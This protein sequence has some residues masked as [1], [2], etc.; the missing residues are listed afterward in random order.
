M[1]QSHKH[2]PFDERTDS[3][4]A[5]PSAQSGGDGDLADGPISSKGNLVG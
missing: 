5:Q 1:E 4:G 3:K 2:G